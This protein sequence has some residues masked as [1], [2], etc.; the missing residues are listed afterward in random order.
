MS[1]PE[2]V[3]SHLTG[4]TP[5]AAKEPRMSGQLIPSSS[6]SQPETGR[7]RFCQ[8]QARWLSGKRRWAVFC[9]SECEVAWRR[10]HYKGN[11]FAA[12][13]GPNSGSF[14]KGLI[15]WNK[16]RK[17]IHLSPE[18]EFRRGQ[19]PV[20]HLPIGT[21]RIRTR[22]R[23]RERRAW[24]KVAEPKKWILR[25]VYVWQTYNGP[26]PKGLIVHH[27]DRNT[28]NDSIGNLQLLDRASHLEEHR[29]ELEALKHLK[30][31]LK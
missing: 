8:K 6:A 25:A 31:C 4:S 19:L 15:P 21:V 26:I 2:Q 24:I 16:N 30:K 12:E 5:L 11:K 14:P 22:K 1:K 27:K 10:E 13:K 28:L 29:R 23:D 18:T 20:T 7:C 17:G 3:L 9:S